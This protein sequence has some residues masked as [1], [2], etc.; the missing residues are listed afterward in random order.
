MMPRRS[1]LSNAWMVTGSSLTAIVVLVVLLRSPWDDPAAAETRPLRL[2]C[3]A[4]MTKPVAEL[5]QDYHKSYGVKV[6]VSY[7]GSGKL[8]STIRAAGGRG[9]LYLAADA[10]HM[11]IAKKEG[12]VAEVLAVAEL[13]PVLIVNDATRK[14]LEKSGKP[15]R[16]LRDILRDDLKVVL[17]NPE[18]ASIGQL[19]KDLLEKAGLWQTVQE[20]MKE[21][22]ARASTVG[23]VNEVTQIVRT[24]D[25]FLGIVWS[26]NAL[27]FEGLHIIDVPELAR[28]VESMQIGVL[29]RSQQP[30]AALRLARYLSARD[31]G[32]VVFKKHH[33][34]PVA[35][36][37]AWDAQPTI[38][39]SAGAMLLPAI[40]DAVKNFARREGVTITTSAGG[41]GLLVGQMKALKG[42]QKPGN[43]PDAYFACDES[44]L[45]DVQDW[46]ETGILVARNPMVL[47]VPKGNPENIQTLADLARP[48][49]RVGLAHPKNSALG[50]LTDDLLTKPGLHE[51]IYQPGRKMP[52][53]HADAAH[54]LV[55]QM[56][57][58]ALDVA[59]V[60][61]SNV[62]SSP[63]NRDKLDV[64]DIDLAEAIAKQPFAIA[65]E[66]DHKHLMRRLLQA[67]VAPDNAR[68][69]GS[70]G[71]Q[72]VYEAP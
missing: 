23:T 41:C 44:F 58:E 59:V 49:L 46:F 30:T 62:L 67:I 38:H 66:S 35:D 72:W 18:L 40:E 53:V 54:L 31:R 64:I 3:A 17:A 52:V 26:A 55:N 13:R 70:L 60:Y 14:S 7:D 57:T 21:S 24:R 19:S 29:A 63:S 27:Q 5:L 16:S 32:G 68:H 34:D 71:F 56:R 42:G 37:D 69:F 6:E 48:D 25:G 33:F 39:L 12:L 50:K 36:A 2:Y 20:R 45:T 9:D 4:G 65:R 1:F 10:S 28:I 8:L 43:F 15:L 61:R 51:D 11:R 47:V 22:A